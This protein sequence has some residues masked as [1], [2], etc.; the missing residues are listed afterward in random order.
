MHFKTDLDKQAPEI[1]FSRKTM[2]AIHSA[3]QF[4]DSLTS[5]NILVC[6][7]MKNYLKKRVQHVQLK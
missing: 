2:K 1:V 7:E 6:F 4:N 5:K 3:V